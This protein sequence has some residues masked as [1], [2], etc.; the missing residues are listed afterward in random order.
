MEPRVQDVLFQMGFTTLIQDGYAAVLCYPWYLKRIDQKLLLHTISNQIGTD[1]PSML[2]ADFCLFC[3]AA[4]NRHLL[5]Q[6]YRKLFL[7]SVERFKNNWGGVT[8]D[9][10]VQF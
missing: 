6:T 5:K 3:K 1:L 4:L 8:V 7:K 2:H 9:R 10:K